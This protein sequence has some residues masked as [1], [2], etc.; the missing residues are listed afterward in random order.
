[1][2]GA[3]QRCQM[4]KVFGNVASY[5]LAHAGAR[6][7]PSAFRFRLRRQ[8]KALRRRYWFLFRGGAGSGL[9]GIGRYA[10]C[11]ASRAC[12]S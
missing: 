4:F 1:M 12:R 10:A 11:M 2:L 6:P 9:V 5:A 8:Q 7:G 3:A